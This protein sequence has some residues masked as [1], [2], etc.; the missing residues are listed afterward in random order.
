MPAVPAPTPQPSTRPPLPPPLVVGAL[1]PIETE[2]FRLPLR[3]ADVLAQ[4]YVKAMIARLW[5]AAA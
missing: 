5:D 2:L 4:A 1:E 3:Y